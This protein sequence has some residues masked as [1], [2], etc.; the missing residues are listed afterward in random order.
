MGTA[1]SI[2]A[3]QRQPDGRRITPLR[4]RLL[5]ALRQAISDIKFKRLPGNLAI[6]G[7]DQL[8]GQLTCLAIST[9][10]ACNT[11]QADPSHVLTAIG[12][13]RS[14]AR[15]SIRSASDET[16]P[17]SA[18]TPQPSSSPQRQPRSATTVTKA[19]R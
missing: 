5:A 13:S 11:R 12:L 9:G 3:D 17:P 10:S 16:Q 7:T 8:I 18:S 4:D 6:P 2:L 1:A 15:A 14:A 19:R